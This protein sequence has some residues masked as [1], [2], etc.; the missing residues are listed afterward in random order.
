MAQGLID[1]TRLVMGE[2]ATI[3][4]V[5]DVKEAEKAY[6]RCLHAAIRF[7]DLDLHENGQRRDNHATVN[8][9]NALQE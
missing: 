1:I 7:C 2:K 8:A 4:T 3:P 5:N 6:Q 9:K